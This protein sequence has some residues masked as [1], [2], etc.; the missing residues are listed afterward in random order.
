MISLDAHVL[1]EPFYIGLDANHF[2]VVPYT[3]RIYINQHP[4]WFCCFFFCF[5]DKIKPYAGATFYF[6]CCIKNCCGSL[7][8]AIYLYVI[9]I[10]DKVNVTYTPEKQSI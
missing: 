5:R 8:G 4:L 7:T 10:D 3:M 9:L 2:H 6:N 1:F